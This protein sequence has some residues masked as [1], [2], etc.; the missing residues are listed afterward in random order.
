MKA[1]TRI[2]PIAAAFTLALSAFA[3]AAPKA[4]RAAK[5]FTVAGTM[6]KINQA[7][8]TLLVKDRSSA[9]LYLINMP[10]GT[11]FKIT[12]GR[13]MRLSEPGFNDV[14]IRE[15]VQIRCLRDD[16]EH[17][18]LLPDGRTVITLTSAQ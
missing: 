2:G 14:F 11:T 3:H 7:E 8:H 5:F 17:L 4:E 1:M 15:R 12:F 18:A 16:K 6:L 10:E 13:Y 9:K